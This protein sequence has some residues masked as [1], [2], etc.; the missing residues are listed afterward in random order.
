MVMRGG[1]L[2]LIFY[3]QK[4]KEKDHLYPEQASQKGTVVSKAS[5]CFQIQ[6]SENRILFCGVDKSLVRHIP[7]TGT[8][9]RCKV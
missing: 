6:A 9:L 5:V 8:A 7:F 2:C 1:L 4:I 3:M